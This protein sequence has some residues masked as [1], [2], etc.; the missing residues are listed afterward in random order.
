MWR[1]RN[2]LAIYDDILHVH[3]L[4]FILISSV[5]LVVN[6][7]SRSLF[8]RKIISF[9]NCLK[10]I[11]ER[12]LY[13]ISKQDWIFFFKQS[14]EI[15]FIK[16]SVSLS[17]LLLKLVQKVRFLHPSWQGSRTSAKQVS[18][19]TSTALYSQKRSNSC[20]LCELPQL[21]L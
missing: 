20:Q 14:T 21:V 12:Q 8:Y 9:L 13:K 5:M 10:K 16:Y 17:Y 7:N 1:Q 4:A 2:I 15:P 3:E 11:S 18:M 6:Y 19:E